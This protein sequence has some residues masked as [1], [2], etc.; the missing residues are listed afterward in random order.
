M[1]SFSQQT[2]LRVK[3]EARTKSTLPLSRILSMPS[4]NLKELMKTSRQHSQ[5]L[6]RELLQKEEFGSEDIALTAFSEQLSRLQNRRNIPP[7][8]VLLSV[9]YLMWNIPQVA[10]ELQTRM[11]VVCSRDYL[12]ARLREHKHERLLGEEKEQQKSQL[13]PLYSFGIDTTTVREGRSIFSTKVTPVTLV[14]RHWLGSV[15]SSWNFSSAPKGTRLI[16]PKLVESVVYNARTLHLYGG[17]QDEWEEH[18]LVSFRSGNLISVPKPEEVM[19]TSGYKVPTIF[20][21]YG[22]GTQTVRDTTM[23]VEEA[24][25]RCTSQYMLLYADYDNYIKLLHQVQKEEATPTTEVSSPRLVP[26]LAGWHLQW[27]QLMANY[28]YWWDSMLAPFVRALS[29]TKVDQSAEKFHP[30]NVFFLSF[31]TCAVRLV[32]S[33]LQPGETLR[34]YYLRIRKYSPLFASLVF[35]LYTCALPYVRH[36]RATRCGDLDTY[37]KTSLYHLKI[38]YLTNKNNYFKG[39]STFEHILSA[40]DDTEWPERIRETMFQYFS[41]LSRYLCAPDVVLEGVRVIFTLD[42][43]SS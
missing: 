19:H 30:C 1:S 34:T 33:Q 7:Q 22:V 42:H 5:Q 29:I 9:K 25:K 39:V 20:G 17:T 40:L 15:N 43:M 16:D 6:V 3:A 11:N 37:R 23:F 35:F 24:R 32:L 4:E 36:V 21:K 10:W 8:Q 13:T 18:I 28:S 41:A 38:F 26:I 27:H 31:T 12:I 2:L 14:L